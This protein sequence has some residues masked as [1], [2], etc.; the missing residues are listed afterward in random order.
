[1]NRSNMSTIASLI[2]I[3]FMTLHITDDIVR[4]IS[5]PG[6]DNIGGVVIFAVWLCGTLLLRNRVAGYVITLLGGIFAA[7]M[8]VM[9]MR[10]AG[11]PAI[12]NSSGGFFFV[13]SLFILGTTGAFSIILAILALWS[14]AR[15]RRTEVSD[16]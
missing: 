4:N 6:A 15:K 14:A 1:M 2:S 9:H 7:A 11:Y 16:N 10:G 3:L 8:P 13:W 12:A 5:P